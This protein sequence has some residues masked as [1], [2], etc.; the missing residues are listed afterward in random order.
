MEEQEKFTE[1]TSSPTAKK[2]MKD[3]ILQK[4]TIMKMMGAFFSICLFLLAPTQAFAAKTSGDI[5]SSVNAAGEGVYDFVTG[6]TFWL[7]VAM[8]SIGFLIMKFKW[9]DRSGTAGKIVM[10]T[11]FGIGGVFA[12]PQI[13]Q[14]V[15]DL[16]K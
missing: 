7:G 12:A 10:N 15:I 8:V 14:F 11:L 9:I 16:V 1:R 2:S 3:R 6:I 5:Q 13:V 4:P